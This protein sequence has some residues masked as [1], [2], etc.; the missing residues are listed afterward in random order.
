MEYYKL[1]AIQIDNF[2]SSIAFEGN[3]G[4]SDTD[5]INQKK[6]ELESNGYVCLV[7]KTVSNITV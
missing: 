2:C 5:K 4:L 1:V 3:Y 7:A 6:A